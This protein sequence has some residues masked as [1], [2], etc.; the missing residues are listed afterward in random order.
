MTPN[1]IAK[2]LGNTDAV[3]HKL[4]AATKPINKE[5]AKI[6][7]MIN[8]LKGL[9]LNKALG[10]IDSMTKPMEDLLLGKSLGSIGAAT[11]PANSD[12]TKLVAMIAL[13]QGLNQGK[14]ALGEIDKVAK[15]ASAAGDASLDKLKSELEKI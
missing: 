11:K 9:S 15:S 12:F 8:P 6:T 14:K 10:N 13:M 7:E 5:F 2:A 4:A 1:S 3:T